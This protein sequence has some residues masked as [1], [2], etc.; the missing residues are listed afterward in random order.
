MKHIVISGGSRGLGL[1]LCQKLLE[2]GYSISSLGRKTTPEV[3]QLQKQY[4]HYFWQEGDLK[5]KT[6][7]HS[8]MEK[9][10]SKNGDAYGLINNAAI[11]QEGILA[12]LPEKN[13]EDMIQINLTGTI[14]L[15]RLFVRNAI[16][17]Q[18]VSGRIINISSI[19]ATRGYNGLSVY[20]ATKGAL[21]S[22]S[23]SLARELGR[24]KITV[25]SI[26]P[27][28]MKTE[29]SKSL[30]SE[31]MQQ[32]VRRTPLGSLADLD[33]VCHLAGFLLSEK[34]GMI[35]GQTILVDGGISC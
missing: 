22:F 16:A 15:T 32:I 33:D 3:L 2:E 5:E 11:A 21:D 35:T 25:N 12:T 9:A 7:L 28:Y 4:S 14:Y 1:H 8:F 27:G 30:D 26:A 24:R 10:L 19:I 34:A 29:M 23:R 17:S 20:S 13:I 31:K 6:S 18:H